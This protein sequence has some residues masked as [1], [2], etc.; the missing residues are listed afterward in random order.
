MS[1]PAIAG[2]LLAMALAAAQPSLQQGPAPGVDLERL[3]WEK[4]FELL[5]E[6]AGVPTRGQAELEGGI[7]TLEKEKDSLLEKKRRLSARLERLNSSYTSDQLYDEML[8]EDTMDLASTK[9]SISAKLAALD[10][11]LEEIDAGLRKLRPERRK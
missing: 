5:L 9:E 1:R 3:K 8:E 11:R 4:D 10:E 2:T 7:A 6:M